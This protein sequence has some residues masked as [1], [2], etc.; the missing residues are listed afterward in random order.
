MLLL[1]F[2]YPNRLKDLQNK[3]GL[4]HS[5]IS[6]LLTVII[7][8]VYT[9]WS[10][11]LTNIGHS[12]WFTNNY[13]MKLKVIVQEK[14]APLTNCIRF[15]DGTARPI[16]KPTVQQK[17]LYSGHKRSHCLKFQSVTLPNGIILHLS[18]PYSVRRHDAFMLRDTLILEQ[19]KKYCTTY[20][21]YGDEGYLLKLQLIRLYSNSTLT[22]PQ[23]QFNSTMSKLRQCVEWSCGKI[24]QQFAYVDLKKNKKFL[25]QPVGKFYFVAIFLTNAHTCL[26]GS[27]TSTYFNIES[28]D[29]SDYF[30]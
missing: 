23:Q 17:E 10:K 25:L 27:T 28:P 3:F 30:K 19:L 11:L 22:E 5:S 18:L 8:Y 21:I 20:C 26:Y 2:A 9:K 7:H 13:Q 12:K 15:K 24:E 14:G 1:R 6:K 16:C 29:I 4:Q